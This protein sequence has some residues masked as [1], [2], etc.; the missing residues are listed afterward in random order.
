MG[1]GV[2]TREPAS[3]SL[4]FFFFSLAVRGGGIRTRDF[5][6][7]RQALYQLSYPTHNVQGRIQT[8]AIDAHASVKVSRTSLFICQT[9]RPNK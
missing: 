1:G 9:L 7:E 3:L 4:F 8:D 5:Q 2:L 6:R